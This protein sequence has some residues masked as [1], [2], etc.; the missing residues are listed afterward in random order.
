VGA[1][2][3]AA[4]SGIIIGLGGLGTVVGTSNGLTQAGTWGNFAEKFN[5]FKDL[6][7]AGREVGDTAGVF[8]TIGGTFTQGTAIVAASAATATLESAAVAGGSALV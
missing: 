5:V 1:A 3:S 7:Q 8:M 4:A 2:I 6:L